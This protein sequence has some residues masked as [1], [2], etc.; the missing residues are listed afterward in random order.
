MRKAQHM[1]DLE[2]ENRALRETL[3]RIS[4]AARRDASITPP[5][6]L[7]DFIVAQADAALAAE[8]ASGEADGLRQARAAGYSKGFADG[9]RA[10]IDYAIAAALKDKPCR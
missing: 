5:N 2:A 3:L 10:A 8:P 9:H 7:L 1:T 6:S 4:T